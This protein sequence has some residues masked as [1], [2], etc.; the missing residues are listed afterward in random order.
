MWWL[1]SSELAGGLEK[2]TL[3]PKSGEIAGF[4]ATP[5]TVIEKMSHCAAGAY[6]LESQF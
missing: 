4:S 2:L 5:K 3:G 1:R 6:I